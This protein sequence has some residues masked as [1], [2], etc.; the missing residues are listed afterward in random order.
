V[1]YKK[2]KTENSELYIRNHYLNFI[3]SQFPHDKQNITY[4]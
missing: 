1:L 2:G 3:S 4:K